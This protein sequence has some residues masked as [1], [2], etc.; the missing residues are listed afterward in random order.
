[1]I[2]MMMNQQMNQMNEFTRTA[3]D[4]TTKAL[5]ALQE[6]TEKMTNLFIDMAPWI[7][8][9]GKKALK[10]WDKTYRKGLE[11]FTAAMNESQK[12]VEGLFAGSC[13]TLP[14]DIATATAK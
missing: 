2:M 5:A 7:P 9:E 13:W 6:Q 3:M 11:E 10:E 12:K 1:M 14:G 4:N 8:E